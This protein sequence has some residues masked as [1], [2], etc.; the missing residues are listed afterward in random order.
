MNTA[1]PPAAC[2]PGC[3]ACCTAPSTSSAIPGLPDGMPVVNQRDANE[4]P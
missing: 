2:R 4:L 3:G 1:L